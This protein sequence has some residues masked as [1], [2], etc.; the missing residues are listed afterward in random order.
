MTQQ[1]SEPTGRQ[2]KRRS[3]V[4]GLHLMTAL[5]CLSLA[6]RARLCLSVVQGNTQLLPGGASASTPLLF[7]WE[8]LLLA[9]VVAAAA[10]GVHWGGSWLS[11]LFWPRPGQWP[12]RLLRELGQGLTLALLLLL[13]VVFQAYFNLLVDM[14]AAL[15]HDV[16]QEAISAGRDGLQGYLS[17]VR[18]LDVLFLALPLAVFLGCQLLPPPALRWRDRALA[19]IAL[20]VLL[21]NL[22]AM[23]SGRP[24]VSPELARDPALFAAADV[25]RGIR[26]SGRLP[27]APPLDAAVDQPSATL[28]QLR[29]GAVGLAPA[30]APAPRARPSRQPTRA[31]QLNSVSLIHPT[32]V[33]GAV[34]Q[35]NIPAAAKSQ[36]WSVVLVIL[37][38]AGLSYVFDRQQ[39]PR[40]PMPFLT[41]LARQ[42]LV[43]AN[44][45]SPHNTSPS[46]LF[47]IFT[48]L[49]SRPRPAIFSFRRGLRYPSLFT[50]LP[51]SYDS[52]MYSPATTRWYF[53]SEYM[54]HRGPR[55]LRDHHQLTRARFAPRMRAYCRHEVDTADA[56][57]ARLDRAADRRGPF[58]AVYY[59]CAAHWPYPDYGPQY[60]RFPARL[61][62][63]RQL[64]TRQRINRYLNNLY[65][66]D[67]QLRRF[68]QL[69]QRREL[70]ERTILVVLGDH[71]QAFGQHRGNWI[72]SRKSFNE[73]F[74]TPAVFHQP[75]LFKPRRVD[76]VTTHVDVAPTLLDAMGL[77]YN[78]R[79]FQGESLYQDQLT[80]RYVF[81][82]GNENTLSSIS[83]D[84][85]KL[86][87]LLKRG[88]CRAFDLN[89][90]PAEQR[91]K[92]CAAYRA[93]RLA[94]RRYYRRQGKTLMR[95]NRACRQGGA[96]GGERH[97]RA[98]Q[99]KN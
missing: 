79:L 45:Y 74:Q 47:A 93:Q 91:P 53:P 83:R 89:Q 80:R 72:H 85:I 19:G 68:Y 13:A 84:G 3:L 38:S 42:S 90:D 10:A 40:T 69:L 78:P 37:E 30:A 60:R 77:R 5:T 95:Y 39:Y 33:T 28:A 82:F 2:P 32:L 6:Y 23:A 61:G 59:S 52:F 7:L 54:R 99:P 18:P 25:I 31:D 46:A 4:V 12:R 41:Q 76:Q 9:L 63:F 81:L 36:P 92:S 1:T 27:D 51:A 65:L 20:A 11:M 73:N 55:Q 14:N 24:A 49:N 26:T 97:P 66:L 48:S 62:S 88:K 56:F 35:K 94:L 44:H 67:Q 75:R 50:L 22:A 17:L 43:L 16:V 34:P 64:S 96:F 98:G 70:L 57:L 21:L 87:L 86:Q 8:D 29:P 15:T 71:G 58:F